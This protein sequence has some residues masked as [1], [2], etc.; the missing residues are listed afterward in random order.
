MVLG[1]LPTALST[2]SH[3]GDSLVCGVFMLFQTYVAGSFQMSA[4]FIT[5][6]IKAKFFKHTQQDLFQ[7]IRFF[8]I[9]VIKTKFIAFV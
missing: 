2:K 9:F 8:F 4:Y 1:V 3:K 6:A 5:F 7:D